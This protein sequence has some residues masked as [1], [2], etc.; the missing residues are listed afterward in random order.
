MRMGRSSAI[1]VYL[2][3]ATLAAIGLSACFDAPE[4]ASAPVPPCSGPVAMS[5][6]SN[7]PRPAF[8]WTP[9]CAVSLV[10]V[11]GPSAI[12][13]TSFRHWRLEADAP[14][15]VPPLPYGEVPD[16][17]KS[18]GFVDVTP[19]LTYRV[20]LFVAGEPSIGVADYSWVP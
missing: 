4:S 20:S 10:V 12:V 9:R 16:G 18:A 15:I 8:D 11:D 7:G 14:V 19:G 6:N 2:A 1:L 13:T 5:V 17:A 3:L